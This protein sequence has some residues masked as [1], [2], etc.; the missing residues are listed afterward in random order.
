MVKGRGKKERE[1][2]SSLLLLL[3]LL[4]Y[5]Q[6]FFVF[7]FSLRSLFLFSFLIFN[8]PIASGDTSGGCEEKGICGGGGRGGGRRRREVGPRRPPRR[9]VGGRRPGDARR[10]GV[11][12][13]RARRLRAVVEA[14][15]PRALV[16]DVGEVAE[17][18]S[19]KRRGDLAPDVE[20]GPRL[21]AV[22]VGDDLFFGFLSGFFEDA[23][24]QK[25]GKRVS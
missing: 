7:S 25:K 4:R 16:P 2:V 8:S 19:Q 24:A 17:E 12:L 18:F 9:A 20:L 22:L 14:G 6:P 5:R 23:S 1:K 3:L 11:G 13:E 10:V 21:D 15:R